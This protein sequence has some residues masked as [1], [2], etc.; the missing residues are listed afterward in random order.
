MEHVL[1]IQVKDNNL[2]VIGTFEVNKSDKREEL[3][4]RL[5]VPNGKIVCH[6]KGFNNIQ[7][8]RTNLASIQK[9]FQNY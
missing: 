5:R 9:I 4:W 2:N 7:N 6:A 3:S 8:L 1:D